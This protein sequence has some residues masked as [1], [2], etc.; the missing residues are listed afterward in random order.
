MTPTVHA[1]SCMQGILP[2]SSCHLSG[3]TGRFTRRLSICHS[4]YKIFS[5][6]AGTLYMVFLFVSNAL[7]L[8]LMIWATHRMMQYE[9]SFSAGLTD[10]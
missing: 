10:R 3:L 6:C 8:L 9:L 7:L 1:T 4:C 2:A 5:E